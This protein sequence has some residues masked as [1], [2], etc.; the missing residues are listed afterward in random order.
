[1][2]VL[3]V[4]VENYIESKIGSSLKDEMAKLIH[5]SGQKFNF[6]RVVCAVACS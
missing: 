6:S 1:M 4:G 3:G 2:N 5:S